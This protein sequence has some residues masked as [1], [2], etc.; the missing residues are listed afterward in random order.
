MQLLRD[1]TT[2]A[3]AYQRHHQGGKQMSA[4]MVLSNFFRLAG[5]GLLLL[6]ATLLF[7]SPALAAVDLGIGDAPGLGQPGIQSMTHPPARPAIL[8]AWRNTRQVLEVEVLVTNRGTDPGKGRIEVEVLDREHN[9]LAKQPLESQPFIIKVPPADTG[10]LP[11]LTVQVPGTY[12]LNKLLDQLD[13]AQDAYCLRVRI[14]TLETIDE[15]RIDNTGIKCYNV[16]TKLSSRD[17]AHHRYYLRNSGSTTVEGTLVVQRPALPAG[18]TLQAEPAPGT[19][20]K[21]NP[22]Q[23]II[24]MLLV[25]SEEKVS[26]GDYLD[27][28]P[29]LVD[30]FNNVVDGT[31]FYVAADTIPPKITRAFIAPGNDPNTVYLVVRA[32]DSIS[33]VA[34]ASGASVEWS[35]DTGFTQNRRTLTYQDGNFLAPTGFDTDLGPFAP[36][37]KVRL[38]FVV[39]DVVGN[40]TR[41]KE[42]EFAIPLT[43]VVEVVF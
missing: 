13:R 39:R 12:N 6:S 23:Y 5:G 25:R 37:T 35:T 20:I 9:V 8:V 18:W 2:H 14:E 40:S 26:D 30:P 19:K 24:G 32:V 7:Y 33:G 38:T 42:V 16:A 43:R 10:G 21:L 22:G 11:G 4:L 29:L 17:S 1:K 41:T 15:N 28:R 34:E 3:F 27:I 31:E 36:E